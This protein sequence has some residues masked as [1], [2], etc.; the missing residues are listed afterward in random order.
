MSFSSLQ[1]DSAI[2][3]V[4]SFFKTSKTAFTFRPP[5]VTGTSVGALLLVELSLANSILNGVKHSICSTIRGAISSP[6][7]S[8]NE[9]SAKIPIFWGS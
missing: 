7:L 1:N 9:P 5:V 3:T 2:S 8:I 4:V 6:G